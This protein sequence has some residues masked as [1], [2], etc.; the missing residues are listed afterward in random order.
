MAGR[1]EKIIKN[2]SQ[3]EYENKKFVEDRKQI[4]EN[5]KKNNPNAINIE[6]TYKVIDNNPETTDNPLRDA[7][8]KAAFM[9]KSKKPEYYI[10]FGYLLDYVKKNIL[11]RVKIGEDHSSNPPIFNIDSDQWNNYMYSLPNQISLDPR[12]CIV[13]NSNFISGKGTVQ[14]FNELWIFKPVDGGES[15]N[16][17]VAY[18]M[19]IYLNFNFVLESLKLDDRGDVNLFE[20]LSNI[21][22]GLNKSLGGINNLEP[23]IDENSNTLKIIDTTPIPGLSENKPTNSYILQLY[24]YNKTGNNYISNFIRKVDLKT[25]ITPEYATMITIGATAG[26][27]VKGTEATAFSKWNTGLRDRYKE[28]FTPGNIDSIQPKG[29][30]DEAELNY[31]EKF[32]QGPYSYYN[33]YGFSSFNP[34]T[35]SLVDDIIEGNISVVTEY[36]KYLLSKE[37]S[38]SGGTIGFIPFKLSFSMDGLSGIKIYNKLNVNT[39][40]L[41]KAYGKNMDLIVTGV[42]HKLSN[43]DWE[44]DLETTVIPKSGELSVVSIPPSSIEN[45]INFV[46]STKPITGNDKISN[47]KRIAN[48]LKSIGFTKAGTIGL[49]GNI[50]GESQANPRAAERNIAVGGLGGIGIV[51]WTASRRRKLEAAANRDNTK[52]LDLNFQLIFLGKELQKSYKST[53]NKL[54]TT[55]S[56]EEA[57]IFVLEKFEVPGTYLNRKSNPNAYTA[58]KNKRIGYAKSIESIVNEIYS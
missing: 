31:V 7:P 13:R 40:F 12:V 20:F 10:R 6:L 4:L 52:I 29:G 2:Y 30:I 57:T 51:Q 8:P 19:N 32:L 11:P 43:S 18:P 14:A 15:T 55:N 49:I 27:Y 47:I 26:G 22:T 23:I 48:Y 36:Y 56:I 42:S 41:P 38:T 34:N 9:L 25:A 33:R 50:L 21:C 46:N 28:E 39:E 44:T 24:G 37:K 17:N 45:S 35:F 54:S 5:F 53:F 3:S 58:T 1:E 16:Y